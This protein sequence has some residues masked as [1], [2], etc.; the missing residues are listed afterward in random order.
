MLT[1]GKCS[2]P[3]FSRKYFDV[4]FDSN[5]SAHANVPADFS[6]S[7]RYELTALKNLKWVAIEV[8]DA[9]SGFT[10]HAGRDF[11]HEGDTI[12]VTHKM[13]LAN[14]ESHGCDR[15]Y[16]TLVCIHT[17]KSRVRMNFLE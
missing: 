1:G 3:L 4:A 12:L 16:F 8:V 10:A 6:R 15:I 2:S 9:D 17:E 13:I 14:R 5:G 7:I 11:Q